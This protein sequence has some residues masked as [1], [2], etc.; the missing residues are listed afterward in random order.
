MKHVDVFLGGVSSLEILTTGMGGYSGMRDCLQIKWF[1][2]PTCPAKVTITSIIRGS[3]TFMGGFWGSELKARVN[4]KF[5]ILFSKSYCRDCETTKYKAAQS[6]IFFDAFRECTVYLW[7]EFLPKNITFI[8]IQSN[9]TLLH[10]TFPSSAQFSIALQILLVFLEKRHP[11]F[12]TLYFL[13]WTGE[14]CLGAW[15]TER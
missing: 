14:D 11:P 3:E 4:V 6:L 2:S 12:W 10:F 9:C 1:G 7:R 13:P 5:R 15:R 8:W